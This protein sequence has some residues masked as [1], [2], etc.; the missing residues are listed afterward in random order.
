M[1]ELEQIITDKEVLDKVLPLVQS[2]IEKARTEAETPI[3]QAMESV[4]LK[5][6]GTAPLPQFLAE[7]YKT[8]SGRAAEADTLRTKIAAYEQ[9]APQFE[10]VKGSFEAK[11]KEL[12]T[13]AETLQREKNDII[14]DFRFS[15]AAS[16]LKIDEKHKAMADVVLGAQKV[17]L[18]DY[19][20]D[21]S[22]PDA[23]V[24]KKAGVIQYDGAT[25]L[26]LESFVLKALKPFEAATGPVPPRQ[27]EGSGNTTVTTAE[28]LA[29]AAANNIN[30]NSAEGQKK[31]R[32]IFK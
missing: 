21:F 30:V 5:R 17:L 13:Q 3:L 11:I 23:T 8:L 1:D 15:K 9:Q 27:G 26:T 14:F 24:L 20:A 4:G 28:K 18:K 10:Q 31:L 29:Y 6:T 22:N 25:P 2:A 19:E 12:E 32:E 7:S 16:L